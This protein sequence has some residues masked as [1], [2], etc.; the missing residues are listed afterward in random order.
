MLLAGCITAAPPRAPPDELAGCWVNRHSG[1][2]MRWT[3]D[4]SRANVLQGLV[5]DQ[6]YSVEPDGEGWKLCRASDNRCWAVARGNGG[7]LEGGRVFIDADGPGVRITVVGDGPA[8][9][10][11]E[12]RHSACQ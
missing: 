6:A 9:L 7:S 3:P 11:F 8:R 1:A 12:G 2:V 4:A 10:L 5:R